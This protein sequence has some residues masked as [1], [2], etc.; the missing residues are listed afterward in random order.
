M[1]LQAADLDRFMALALQQAE[2]AR[3][4]GE[5]PVGAVV[6]LGG[7]VIGVGYNRNIG[8]H[9]PSAHAEIM[10]LRA[11]SEIL[12]NHRLPGANLYVTLE[13]CV[14]CAGAIMH[15]RINTLVY[16]A[17]DERWGAAGSVANVVQSPLLNHRCEVISGVKKEQAASLLQ[18][19]FRSRRSG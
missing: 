10:A 8:K 9:D 3:A 6:E 19:F 11:A 17:A 18:D 2:H 5:V 7:K 13:P 1:S 16:G 14:M 4:E 12:G 15:A